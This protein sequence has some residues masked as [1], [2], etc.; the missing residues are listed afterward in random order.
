MEKERKTPPKWLF[1]AIIIPI[2]ILLSLVFR[3][4]MVWAFL[5]GAAV[6][7]IV[8]VVLTLIWSRRK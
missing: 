6:G 2:F 4:G 8:H 3:M 7:G 1:L 5:I